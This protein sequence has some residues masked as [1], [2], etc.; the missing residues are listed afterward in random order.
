MKNVAV[1]GCGPTGLI[2]AQAA[3]TCG[4]KVKI[5]SAKRPSEIY[6]A[7]Y[8]HEPIP[9]LHLRQFKVDYQT[10]G[11]PESYREKVYGAAW[12]GTVSPEDF[13]EPHNAWDLREAYAQLWG[14]WEPYVED[15]KLTNFDQANAAVGF[16]EFDIVI[17]TIPRKVWMR[18][19]DQFISQ[20]VWAIGTGIGQEPVVSLPCNT[21]VCNG[22]ETPGWYRASNI[23][24]Y[25]TV[26]WP[27][28]L[29]RVP[30]PGVVKI[31]KPLKFVPGP[32]QIE[33]NMIYVGRYGKWE[34]GVL[35]TDAFRDVVEALS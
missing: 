25:Q 31:R 15:V 17:S 10:W 28:S 35:T 27:E 13:P 11:T 23:E 4:A 26:E 1:L 20:N 6:G 18:P 7:Q 2:A 34:K 24:G 22:Q 5:F 3:F 14:D 32:E 16:P 9:G 29:R 12:D 8:L 33:S 21:V 30:L 19:G